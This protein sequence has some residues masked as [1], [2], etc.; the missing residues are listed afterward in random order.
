M[1]LEG[2]ASTSNGYMEEKNTK[3]PGSGL[4]FIILSTKNYFIIFSKFA[5]TTMYLSSVL[6]KPKYIIKYV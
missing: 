5:E 1:E 6:S 3:L 2:I 4:I